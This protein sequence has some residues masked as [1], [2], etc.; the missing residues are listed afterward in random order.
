MYEIVCLVDGYEKIIPALT[1]PDPNDRHILA[2]AIRSSSSVIVT[3][4]LKDFPDR[5]INEFGIEAQHPDDFLMHLIDLSS[6]ITC[7]AIRRLRL[8]LKNPPMNPNEYLECLAK[9]SL[10]KTIEKLREFINEI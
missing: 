8:G 3:Y 6:Q 10:A 9:Q 4:N 1:L 2:A 5:N 7:A